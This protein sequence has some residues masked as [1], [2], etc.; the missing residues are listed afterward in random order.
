MLHVLMMIHST[1]IC[2]IQARKAAELADKLAPIDKDAEA[3]LEFEAKEEER[4]ITSVCQ[5]LNL[6]MHEVNPIY[7][8]VRPV[9]PTLH[10]STQTVIASSQPSQISYLSLASS[11]H[12]RQIIRLY[13]QQQR[14]ICWN[15]RMTSCPSFL[16]YLARMVMVQQMMG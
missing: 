9:K 8:H 1:K 7:S 16:P 13:D 11:K 12:H 3:K 14:N 10:R 15:I 2:K 4:V 5:E 6:E